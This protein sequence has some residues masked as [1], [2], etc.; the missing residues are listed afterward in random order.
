MRLFLNLNLKL[1]DVLVFLIVF[2]DEQIEA[3]LHL[4]KLVLQVTSAHQ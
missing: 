4:L 3:L 1:F 2:K